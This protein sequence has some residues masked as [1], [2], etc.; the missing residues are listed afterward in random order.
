MIDGEPFRKFVGDDRLMMA[1]HYIRKVGNK[2]AHSNVPAKSET[3][4]CLRTD[5]A[6][7]L[8]SPEHQQEEFAR[9]LHDDLKK[10][11]CEQVQSLND[12][13]IAVRQH[14]SMV[15][16]Y[17]K[18]ESWVCS[19][20]EETVKIKNE[21][22]P[23][24]S[25]TMTDESAK[26]FDV[27]MLNIELSKLLPEVNANRSQN[28]VVQIAQLLKEKANIPQVMKKMNI[29]EEVCTSEFWE[30]PTL[31]RLERVRKFTFSL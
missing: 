23:L 21:L 25:R 31:S 20:L 29:L 15:D 26:K 18:A 27:L 2:A 14:W 9:K 1:V 10:M 22:S 7:A 17:R 6:Y 8:Q 11:L 16:K 12:A 5:I 28:K 24:L 13:Q 3:Y 30:A 4:F 19:S